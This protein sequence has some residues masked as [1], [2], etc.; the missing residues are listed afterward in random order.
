MYTA[1]GA[2]VDGERMGTGSQR[3]IKTDRRKIKLKSGLHLQS[4]ISLGHNHA[5]AAM[6]KFQGT[7]TGC[8]YADRQHA[9]RPRG[10]MAGHYQQ[11]VRKKIPRTACSQAFPFAGFRVVEQARLPTGITSSCRRWSFWQP[12]GQRLWP[13][14]EPRAWRLSERQPSWALLS[15]LRRRLP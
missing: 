15:L 9:S 6:R 7:S 8:R 13:T 5:I 12:S 4:A 3:L 2:T 14:S 11:A 1:L 10:G